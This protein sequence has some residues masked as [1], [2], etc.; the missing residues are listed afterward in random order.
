MSGIGNAILDR[1]LSVLW[2]SN[3]ALQE[4]LTEPK[5]RAAAVVNSAIGLYPRG[6]RGKALLVL[7]SWVKM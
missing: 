2:Y 5:I 7:L 3:S 1:R 6:G 4:T